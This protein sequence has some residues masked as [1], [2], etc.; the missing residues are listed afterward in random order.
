[1]KEGIIATKIAAHAGDIAK[2]VPGAKAW[3]D[4]MSQ[5]RYERDWDKMFELS[6]DDERPRKYRAESIPEKED[7]C[8]M[9]GKMCS[10]RTVERILK[11]ED[12]NLI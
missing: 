11:N 6:L 5:A 9:C 7:S 10:M 4:A 1:M 2:G 12:V 3:D 8:T